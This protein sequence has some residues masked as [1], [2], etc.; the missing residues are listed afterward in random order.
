MKKKCTL[1]L[2]TLLFFAGLSMVAHAQIDLSDYMNEDGSVNEEKIGVDITSGLV[3]DPIAFAGELAEAYPDKAVEIAI[4]VSKAS[5][6]DAVAISAA[7][8][9]KVPEQA[10]AIIAAISALFPDKADEIKRAVEEFD[11]KEATTSS[12]TTSSSSTT[13]TTTTTTS[14]E[15]T[16]SPAS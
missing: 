13:T 5:P 14:K 11:V 3:P 1:I 4:A 2:C 6:E 16:V 8:A 7:V 12:T 10:A 15:T 9:A